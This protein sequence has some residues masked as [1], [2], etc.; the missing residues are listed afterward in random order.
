VKILRLLVLA[1]LV[2]ASGC[3]LFASKPPTK[4]VTIVPI[5][6]QGGEVREARIAVNGQP[7]GQG[8]TSL[9][10]PTQQVSVSVDASPQYFAESFTITPE[11]QGAVRVALRL[12]PVFAITIQDSNKVMNRWLSLNAA[13]SGDGW[14]SIVVNAI[15]TQDFEIEMMDP[16]SGF[17]RTAWKER[18]FGNDG[19]R[20]R[21]VGN[22][23]TA[24][25]LTWRLKYQVQRTTNGRDWADYPRGLKLELDAISE[26]RARM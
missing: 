12:D 11:S 10:V 16:Q 1:S 14:W 5:D 9:Q 2:V 3:H 23:V 13:R 22:V 17:I 20:R 19:L 25:P 8:T 21:F 15:A 18:R 7:A 26:I 24:S 4:I 6:E